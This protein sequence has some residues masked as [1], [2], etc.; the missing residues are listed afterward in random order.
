MNPW[1]IIWD[2]LGWAVLAGIALFVIAFVIAAIM[3]PFQRARR[4]R[5]RTVKIMSSN[6]DT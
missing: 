3:V 5:N 4:R 1:G 6:D 2:V